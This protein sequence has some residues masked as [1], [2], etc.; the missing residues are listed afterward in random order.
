[1]NMDKSGIKNCLSSSNIFSD[2][3][4]EPVT[5]FVIQSQNAEKSMIQFNERNKDMFD[6]EP[7]YVFETVSSLS[8][9]DKLS[10]FDV[11]IK[12]GDFIVLSSSNRDI[13]NLLDKSLYGRN[14]CFKVEEVINNYEIK[15]ENSN[16]KISCDDIFMR[17]SSIES[18]YNWLVSASFRNLPLDSFLNDLSNNLND[19]DLLCTAFKL[20]LKGYSLSKSNADFIS[21]GSSLIFLL[22]IIPIDIIVN[23]KNITTSIKRL[24]YDL[25]YV[26]D[27]FRYMMDLDMLH[28]CENLLNTLKNL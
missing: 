27:N 26:I 18:Y 15:I 20:N 9:Y 12:A 4:T 7:E 3:S 25:K 10:K 14:S 17:F 8:T 1:M 5:N 2:K 28:I 22:E 24:E 16:I 11:A 19:L 6:L 21:N 13:N 23:N